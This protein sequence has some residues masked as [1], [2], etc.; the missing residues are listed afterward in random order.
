MS[1]EQASLRH[2][3]AMSFVESALMSLSERASTRTTISVHNGPPGLVLRVRGTL[4][5]RGAQ[6]LSEVARAALLTMRRARRIHVDLEQVHTD[7]GLPRIVNRLARAGA[8]VTPPA[9]GEP[10]PTR[11]P[12]TWSLP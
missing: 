9:A 1:T 11:A 4:D 12:G 3:I 10:T 8:L 6:L 7:R 2:T 5:E